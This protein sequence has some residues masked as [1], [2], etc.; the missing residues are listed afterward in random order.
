[1][2][3]G[4]VGPRRAMEMGT[5]SA[6]SLGLRMSGA[7]RT[8]SPAAVRTSG[9]AGRR[10]LVVAPE[11]FYEDRGT[12]IAV[13]NVLEALSELHYSVDLL[14]YPVGQPVSIPRVRVL[15]LPNPFGF[16]HVPVGLS[17]RKLLLDAILVPALCV[18][19]WRERYA[20]VHA[21]EEAAFPAVVLGNLRRIPVIYDMQSSLPEQLVKFR[22]FRGRRVQ[23]LLRRCEAWLLRRADAIVSSAGLMHRV[24]EAAPGKLA[25]EWRFPSLVV[26]PKRGAGTALRAELGIPTAAP[27]VVYA[28]TF[29]PYQGLAML[30]AAIPRVRELVPDAVFVLVGGDRESV[31]QM[32]EDAKP[33][34][35]HGSL[36]LTGRKPREEMPA[37]LAMADLLVSPRVYGDNLPLKIFDYLAAGRPIVATD[38]PSH[39]ALLDDTRAILVEPS[40]AGLTSGIIS[41]LSDPPR[42]ARLAIAARDYADTNLGWSGFLAA[43]K[44]VYDEVGGKVCL[45]VTG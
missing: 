38:L 8:A 37:Y 3:E 27:V 14:T 19:L 15:R 24:S 1:V 9:E 22:A 12:P 29:E 26:T 32:R 20:C 43:V 28:G 40:A 16:R 10:V 33:L 39:R 6:A 21:V 7:A 42:A 45:P 36:V 13:R 2:P 23:R 44:A 25:Q 11:P 18:Q 34:D 35:L 17:G 4:S 31:A 5:E 41:L 30:L